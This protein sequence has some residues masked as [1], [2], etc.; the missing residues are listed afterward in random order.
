VRDLSAELEKLLEHVVGVEDGRTTKAVQL[1]RSIME[2]FNTLVDQGK[3]PIQDTP[4][5][6]RSAQDVLTMVSLILE[7]L[8]EEHTSD[9]DSRA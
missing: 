8:R 5:Q 4:A 9:A 7:R 6:L 2:I 3:F 1:S